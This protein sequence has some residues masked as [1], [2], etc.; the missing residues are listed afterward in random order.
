MS[1]RRTGARLRRSILIA[2]VLA[3]LLAACSNS[4]DT[5]PTAAASGAS[6]GAGASNSDTTTHVA[7]S[8]VPGV[9]DTEIDF[10]SLGTNSNNPLGTCVLDCFDDGIK[11]YFDFRNSTG[12]VYGRKLVL[13]K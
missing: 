2:A 4:S 3:L 5:K 13:S 6:S 8:G 11:A 10:S 7:L 9:T 12:G 1:T